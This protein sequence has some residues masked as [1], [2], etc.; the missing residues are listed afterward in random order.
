MREVPEW[1]SVVNMI[2]VFSYV[3][4][5]FL[6]LRA[7]GFRGFFLGPE[8]VWNIFDFLI[9]ALSLSETMLEIMALMS[10]ATNLDSSYLRSI[11]FIRVVRALRGIRVIRLIHYIGALRTLVFSIVSTAG[12]LV[13]TLVLLIL[14]F[15]IFGVIIAQIVTDH[16]RESAQRSTGDL[17]ALPSCEKDASRYWFG[18]SESMFTLFMAITGGISWE[19]ALKPLRDISSVAVACMVLY[20]VIAVFAILNVLALWC[21]CAFIRA[22]G[23]GP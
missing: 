9:V 4:E 2:I 16:C 21:T 7:Y 13:W 1:F 6:K 8:K 18:V 23:G 5:I 19:D 17:D 3:L 15:Y 12:S 14:V 10:S 22:S 11:R 20:I